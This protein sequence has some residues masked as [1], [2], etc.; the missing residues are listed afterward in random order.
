MACIGMC[1]RRRLHADIYKYVCMRVYACI[2][3]FWRM[4]TY[5][6]CNTHLQHGRMT[7]TTQHGHVQV[8][9]PVNLADDVTATQKGPMNAQQE[10]P[11]A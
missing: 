10:C 1:R 5:V 7:L 4:Q 2:H 8:V 3:V 6:T 9:A 11:V